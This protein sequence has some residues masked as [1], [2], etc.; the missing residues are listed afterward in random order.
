MPH[1]SGPCPA[2]LAAKFFIYLFIWKGFVAEK[3]V[4]VFTQYHLG[5]QPDL[6]WAKPKVDKLAKNEILPVEI[7]IF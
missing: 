4:F 1:F 3:K 2:Q 5:A 7:L 6:L